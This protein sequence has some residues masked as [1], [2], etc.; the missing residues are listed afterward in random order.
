M[1]KY[2]KLKGWERESVMAMCNFLLKEKKQSPF[3]YLLTD[4]EFTES[5]NTVFGNV[6]L[7]STIEHQLT[8]LREDKL[9]IYFK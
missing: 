5:T 2:I 3:S 9:G 6:P 7:G 4:Q 1:C 8:D